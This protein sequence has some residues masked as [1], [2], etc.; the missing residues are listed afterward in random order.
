[1][2]IKNCYKYKTSHTKHSITRCLDQKWLNLTKNSPSL[3]HVSLFTNQVCLV[4]ISSYVQG[5]HIYQF[6][7]ICILRSKLIWTQQ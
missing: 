4:T 3:D 7:L 1:M 2:D 6:K 5:I